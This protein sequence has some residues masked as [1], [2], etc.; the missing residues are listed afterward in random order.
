MILGPAKVTFVE[1]SYACFHRSGPFSTG[2]ARP[3]LK[4]CHKTRLSAQL[5]ADQFRPFHLPSALQ[6]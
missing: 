5:S 1:L 4:T 2:A 3:L 6:G